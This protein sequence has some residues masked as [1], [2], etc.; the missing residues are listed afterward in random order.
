MVTRRST[1][2]RT[3]D[4]KR[5][6]GV[7]WRLRKKAARIARFF[8]SRSTA[9]MFDLWLLLELAAPITRDAKKRGIVRINRQRRCRGC[10]QDI[11][12]LPAGLPGPEKQLGR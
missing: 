2:G 6:A 12:S 11:R 10:M 4:E 5:S 7:L 8:G 1:A 3:P 9:P